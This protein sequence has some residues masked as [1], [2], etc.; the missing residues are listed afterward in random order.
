MYS[1]ENPVEVSLISAESAALPSLSLENSKIQ[2]EG[3]GGFT[4]RL[5]STLFQSKKTSRNGPPTCSSVPASTS[6]S[7][8]DLAMIISE[9][10]VCGV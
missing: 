2:L 4:Q 8:G 1:G 6:L 9:S 5:M 3:A 10:R 7:S